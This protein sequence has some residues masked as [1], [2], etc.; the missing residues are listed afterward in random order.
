MDVGAHMENA[1]KG[2]FLDL[3]SLHETAMVSEMSLNN[4]AEEGGLY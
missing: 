1:G 4:T 3:G 2:M